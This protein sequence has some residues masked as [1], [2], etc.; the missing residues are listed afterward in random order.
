MASQ[1][2]ST[3]GGGTFDISLLSIDDDVFEVLATASDTHLGGGDWGNGVMDH[4]IKAHDTKTGPD[5][6]QNQHAFGKLNGEAKL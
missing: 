5:V 3:F 2:S 1:R 4:F 6:S